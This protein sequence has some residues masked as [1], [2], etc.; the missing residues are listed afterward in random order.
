MLQVCPK[1]NSLQVEHILRTYEYTAEEPRIIGP[2]IDCIKARAMTV[3]RCFYMHFSCVKLLYTILFCFFF[4]KNNE[5][6]Y[7]R[8][9]MEQNVCLVMEM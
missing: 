6:T 4:F 2:L 3:V 7:N 1:L 8:K 5:I 9:I